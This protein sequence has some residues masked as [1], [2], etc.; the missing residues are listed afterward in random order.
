MASA[1]LYSLKGRCD[2][3]IPTRFL[4]PIDCSKFL[5]RNRFLGIDSWAPEKFE[6]SGSVS[7]TSCSIPCKK[8]TRTRGKR[9]CRYYSFG[10]ARA[11][12]R[13]YNPQRNDFTVHNGGVPEALYI[14]P[15]FLIFSVEIPLLPHSFSAAV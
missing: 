1:S 6:N 13:R 2:N 8:L 7:E 3:P 14:L 15:L 10:H 5:H 12:E 9:R 11:V 4:A